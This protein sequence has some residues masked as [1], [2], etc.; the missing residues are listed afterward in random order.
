MVI[1]LAINYLRQ[2]LRLVQALQIAY[3]SP[4][5]PHA[6]FIEE[7]PRLRIV[8]TATKEA[9]LVKLEFFEN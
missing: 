2:F 9:I 8:G 4:I 5:G 7:K 6:A 3:A 1:Y